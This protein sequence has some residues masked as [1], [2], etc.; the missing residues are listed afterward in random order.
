MKKVFAG[1]IAILMGV[2]GCSSMQV[3]GESPSSTSK[4]LEDFVQYLESGRNHLTK[5]NLRLKVPGTPE[6]Q[7][8]K[9]GEE[10]T[11]SYS[12]KRSSLRFQLKGVQRVNEEGSDELKLFFNQQGVLRDYKFRSKAP[13]KVTER[14]QYGYEISPSFFGALLGVVTAMI[15]GALT[16]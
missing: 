14:S 12:T 16:R 10:W 7:A 15:L 11:Y 13:Q 3:K 9:D 5:E 1:L 8:D 6:V 2:G 4:N